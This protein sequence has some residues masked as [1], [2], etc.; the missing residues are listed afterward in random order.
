MSRAVF[1]FV[2]ECVTEHPN[3]D[4]AGGEPP[5]LLGTYD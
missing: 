1:K 4:R 3:P 5:P 2:P